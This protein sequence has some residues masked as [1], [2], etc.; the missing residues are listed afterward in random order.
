MYDGAVAAICQG[1]IFTVLSRKGLPTYR[2]YTPRWGG[3][4]QESKDTLKVYTK[5]LSTV[6]LNGNLFAAF[7]TQTVENLFLWS[8]HE[9]PSR[10]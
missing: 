9:L 4:F 2:S 3:K 7:L 6:F 8:F 10:V 1:S 5:L